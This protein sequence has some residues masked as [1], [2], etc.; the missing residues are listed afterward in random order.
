MV[1]LA[2]LGDTRLARVEV[3]V[4]HHAGLSP[5]ALIVHSL[6]SR[7]SVLIHTTSGLPTAS[8]SNLLLMLPSLSRSLAGSIDSLSHDLLPMDDGQPPQ[9]KS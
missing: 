2:L 9:R 1:V 3:G 6:Y 4:P 5:W 7:H 8:M